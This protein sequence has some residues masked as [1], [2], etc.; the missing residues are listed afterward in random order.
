MYP[1]SSYE[2]AKTQ[3]SDLHRRAQR[4][5]LARAARRVRRMRTDRP[6]HPAPGHPSV[7]VRRLLTALGARTS[8]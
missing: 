3:V 4:D 1:F 8:A 7:A 2:L 6:G 5:G